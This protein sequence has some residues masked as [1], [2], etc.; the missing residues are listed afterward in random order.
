MQRF[1]IRRAWSVVATVALAVGLTPVL[2][3]GTAS[4]ATTATVHTD[5]EFFDAWT[6]TSITQID[7]AND[8][9]LT[10]YDDCSY[11]PERNTTGG[12]VLLDGHG[13]L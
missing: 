2:F 8:I 7:L 10:Q 12:A 9:S 11:Y 13:D 4:A 5:A 1:R 3:A 6:N